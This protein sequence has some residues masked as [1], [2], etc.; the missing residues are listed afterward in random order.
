MTVN[1][2]NQNHWA[3]VAPNHL[4][5]RLS[6]KNKPFTVLSAFRK[7]GYP[8]GPQGACLRD[9]RQAPVLSTIKYLQ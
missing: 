3:S 9:T 4:L 5:L 7:G 8:A 6:N 2:S 1:I